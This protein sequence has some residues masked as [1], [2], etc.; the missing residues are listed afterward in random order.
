M[1]LSDLEIR[2][3]VAE[4]KA[5]VIPDLYTSR[6]LIDFNVVMTALQASE[7]ELS[8]IQQLVDSG[9][10]ERDTLGQTLLEHPKVYAILC[11][12]LAIS[13]GVELENSRRLPPATTPPKDYVAATETAEVLLELGLGVLL[14]RPA[15]V[16][17][18]FILTQITADAPR[19]RFRLDA[20]IKGRIEL[21][22]K[23]TVNDVEVQTGRKVEIAGKNTL[24][25]AARGIADYSILVDGKPKFAIAA[26]FQAYT[27]GRQSRDFSALYPSVAQTLRNHDISLILIADG[28]GVR[29]LSDRVLRDLF[30]ALPQTMTISQAEQGGLEKTLVSE[31]LTPPEIGIDEI[32]INSLITRALTEGGTASSTN[33]PVPPE[34]AR[35]A[36]ANF[37]AKH[38]HLSL[39][40]T[41]DASNLSWSQASLVQKFRHSRSSSNAIGMIEGLIALLGGEILH[42]ASS[43]SL[44]A[45]T[46][47]LPDDPVLSQ[48]FLVAAS[49]LRPTP[50]ILRETARQALQFAPESRVAVLLVPE[51]VTGSALQQLRDV[52]AFLPVTVAVV[53][54][55]TCIR[56]A[57]A[58]ELPRDRL[59]VLLLE[60][61][62]LTKLS[63]FVVRGVAPSRVFFGREQEEATLLS[64][65]S[66]NSVALL[67]GRRIG[68]TSLMRHSFGRLKAANMRPFFG[69]CQVARTWNDFGQLA[70]REWGF[71]PIDGF[72]PQHLFELVAHLDDNSGSPI[73]ILLDEIDQL[74]DWDKSHSED[75]VPE[76]FF[77][78]CR[79]I[80]Q[81][82]RAQFVFSGE[83]TIANSLWDATSPHWN[84]CRPLMLQQLNRSEADSLLVEPLEALGV[85]I[86][87]NLEFLDAA[88]GTTDGHPELLQFLGDKLVTLVNERDRRDVHTSPEDILLVSGQYD[89]SEQYLETYWGQATPLERV[90][91]ILLLDGMQ[92]IEALAKRIYELTGNFDAA[93]IQ[94]ALRMLELYGIANQSS[95]GYELRLSWFATAL[96]AYGGPTMAVNRYLGGVK[97]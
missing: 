33:L 38:S 27:G 4:F 8:A 93:Q 5:S 56:M 85:R 43:N 6:D 23:R 71:R 36:L 77:R 48:N 49:N 70:T 13:S 55:E 95:S 80:S 61:T 90:I 91:S 42:D 64:T 62:D 52:Q 2:T 35:L 83:R 17:P 16:E 57:Q 44:V 19:R 15:N 92:S 26:T 66:T 65:L 63:P 31:I 74:L 25:A 11:S 9:M 79:A 69:D 47:S 10:L 1:T 32:G 46:T 59:R 67:G 76:A 20:R 87:A 28:L 54:V 84:F 89:Y 3:L 34:K 82:G 81:Q 7:S 60:Q 94:S 96:N 29:A 41:S 73:I 24:P 39:S 58:R 14:R 88:W 22:V 72:R 37:A 53:D 78:A 45:R 86:E 30:R 50:D 12:F 21:L 75:E 68:K 40:L 18:L 97:Q 51:G